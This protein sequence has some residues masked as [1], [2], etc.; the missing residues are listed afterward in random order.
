MYAASMTVT[1]RM[2]ECDIIVS[3]TAQQRCPVTGGINRTSSPRVATSVASR[4]CHSTT[5]RHHVRRSVYLL[6][7]AER[8]SCCD[9]LPTSELTFVCPAAT[10]CCGATARKCRAREPRCCDARS[11]ATV[12]RCTQPPEAA[13]C[14]PL[15]A[16]RSRAVVAVPLAGSSAGTSLSS[17]VNVLAG[18]RC[19]IS[20][21]RLP[22]LCKCSLCALFSSCRDSLATYSAATWLRACSCKH[23]TLLQ[24]ESRHC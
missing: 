23:A 20:G 13:G 10:G 16:R 8:R 21:Q 3:L 11:G 12:D 19:S 14:A 15:R 9:A 18:L 5:S 24:P 1:D 6:S 4:S 17:V 7:F 22:N 2:G